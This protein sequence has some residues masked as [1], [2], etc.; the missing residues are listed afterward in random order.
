MA[1]VQSVASASHN[2]LTGLN[3]ALERLDHVAQNVAAGIKSTANDDSGTFAEKIG[4]LAQ[5]PSISMQ[6]RANQKVLNTIRDL[7]AEFLTNRRR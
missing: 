5:M 7:N 4:A 6:A 2:A 3:R 1:S